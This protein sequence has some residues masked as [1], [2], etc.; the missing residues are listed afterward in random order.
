[1]AYEENLRSLSHNADASLGIYTGVPGM[2]GS[3]VPNSGKQYCAVKYTGNNQVGLAVAAADNVAGVLQNKPQVPGAAA[4]VGYEGITMA[5]AGAAFAANVEL[6]P[7]ATGRFIAGAGTGKG[8]KF[9][10]TQAAN[11]ADEVVP[12]RM[13]G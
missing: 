9:I 5:R 6:V 4:T 12:V 10:S 13:I 1:V 3:A 8:L 11:A 2:P 7:D